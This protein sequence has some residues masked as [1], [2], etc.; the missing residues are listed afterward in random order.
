MPRKILAASQIFSEDGDAST[1]SL[2]QTRQGQSLTDNRSVVVVDRPLSTIESDSEGMKKLPT[3]PPMA[4]RAT[5]M[6]LS[7]ENRGSVEVDNDCSP[8]SWKEKSKSHS[9]LLLAQPITA[10][11]KLELELERCM[12]FSRHLKSSN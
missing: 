8:S 1:S 5:V 4:R 12:F 3:T 9:H 7:R 6:T 10:L 2:G 11:D